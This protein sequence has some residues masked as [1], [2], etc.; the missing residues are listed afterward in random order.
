ME[1]QE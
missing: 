1:P